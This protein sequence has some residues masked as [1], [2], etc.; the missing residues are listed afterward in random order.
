MVA[1]LDVG[2]APQNP[3]VNRMY[4]VSSWRWLVTSDDLGHKESYIELSASLHPPI[5]L[6]TVHLG[7]HQCGSNAVPR[8]G[9]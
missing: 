5:S 9:P 7:S 1:L 8:S 4:I 6:S 2:Q 3:F